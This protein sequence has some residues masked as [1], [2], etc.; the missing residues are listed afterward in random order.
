[1]KSSKENEGNFNQINLLL[2][3]VL[4][5]ISSSAKVPFLKMQ[6]LNINHYSIGYFYIYSYSP[7]TN[8]E[9]HGD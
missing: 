6:V 1:M 5:I 4:I 2:K 7:F 8:M 9:S 3:N